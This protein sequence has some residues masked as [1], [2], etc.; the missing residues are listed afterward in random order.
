MIYKHMYDSPRELFQLAKSLAMTG[1][2]SHNGDADFTGTESFEE[3]VALTDNGW[4]PSELKAKA[5][6]IGL[7]AE[8]QRMSTKKDNR[9]STLLIDRYTEG[10]PDCFRRKYR[11]PKEDKHIP[12][13]FEVNEPA[14]VSKNQMFLK[15]SVI[16]QVVENLRK[17]GISTSIYAYFAVHGYELEIIEAIPVKKRS[18][19][20]QIHKLGAM[21]HP[22]SFRR[23]YFGRLENGSKG[24]KSENNVLKDWQKM[25][26]GSGYGRPTKELST[27]AVQFIKD[28]LK[29]DRAIIISSI[30]ESSISLRNENDA[31]KWVNKIVDDCNAMFK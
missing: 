11:E 26:F 21:M 12:L 16:T 7:R 28:S 23:I 14:S 8:K 20:L 2:S 13:I 4:N 6:S 9:G 1:Q 29:I 22:S 31:A 25:P 17:Q 27:N 10:S 5:K 24:R 19:R 15:A 30:Y 18:E 3:A